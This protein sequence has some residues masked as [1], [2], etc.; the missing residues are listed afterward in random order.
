M[1]KLRQFLQYGHSPDWWLDTA[2][3]W[4][5]NRTPNRIIHSAGSLYW[6]LTGVER[7]PITDEDWDTL[8]LLDACRY[9]EFVQTSE[10]PGETGVRYSIAPRTPEFLDKTFSDGTY[11]D[12]V[13]VTANP[14]VHQQLNKEQFH[15]VYNVW[16]THWNEVLKSV[17]PNAVI[18]VTRMALDTYPNKRII[19]HF[20]Q[21][22]LPFIGEWA[23]EHIGIYGGYEHAQQ[24][25]GGKDSVEWETDPYAL[26]SIGEVSIPNIRRAYKENLQVAL[27]AVSPLIEE[28]SGKT[29]ITA[30]HG[31]LLGDAAWPYPWREYGHPDLE[32]RKSLEVPWHI[33]PHETRRTIISDRPEMSATPDE[34]DE[35]EE[36]LND[37]GYW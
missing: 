12:I 20:M 15:A 13:Y 17:H 6:R 27:D 11:H 33:C 5:K 21:P 14:H 23:R 10:L 35:I 34:I 9:D 29:V 36:K 31:E 1:S 16:D 32:S 24:S 26:A 18:E 30:D 22:H 28:I 37:L 4:L 3:P 19:A 7:R 8:L 2:I 25:A